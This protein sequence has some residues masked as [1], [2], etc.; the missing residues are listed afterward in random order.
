MYKIRMLYESE[1]RNVLNVFLDEPKTTV[2]KKNKQFH[3]KW[4][5]ELKLLKN[6]SE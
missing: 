1:Q 4:D 3:D 6:K 2:K 5:R